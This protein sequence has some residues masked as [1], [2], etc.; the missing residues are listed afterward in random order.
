MRAFPRTA[1]VLALLVLPALAFVPSGGA[2][3]LTGTPTGCVTDFYRVEKAKV[4]RVA[5]GAQGWGQLALVQAGMCGDAHPAMPEGPGSNMFT[6]YGA[7]LQAQADALRADFRDHTGPALGAF[8]GNGYARTVLLVLDADGALEAVLL[9]PLPG[10][11]DGALQDPS[12]ALVGGTDGMQA[13]AVQTQDAAAAGAACAQ[14]VPV[15][16]L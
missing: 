14:Q 7:D 1:A 3:S 6:D 10:T 11:V 16:S 12:A 9:S 8:L 4:N 2:C 13:Y 5:L 15:P